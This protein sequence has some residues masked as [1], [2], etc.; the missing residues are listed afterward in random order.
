MSRSYV[1][2]HFEN[3]TPLKV[4][5]VAK[6]SCSFW[7][8]QRIQFVMQPFCCSLEPS[9]IP[10]NLHN[11][12][13]GHVSEHE[14]NN[15]IFRFDFVGPCLWSLLCNADALTRRAVGSNLEGFEDVLAWVYGVETLQKSR[16]WC[17]HAQKKLHGQCFRK[18]HI[19]CIF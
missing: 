19:V 4:E 7:C 9:K 3:N 2:E 8:I 11:Y 17:D 6:V 13:F 10:A 14:M 5:D 15:L 1:D 18:P 16:W 12:D